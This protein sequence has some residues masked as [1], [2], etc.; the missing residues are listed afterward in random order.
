MNKN[1]KNLKIAI[2]P[3]II[4]LLTLISL[5]VFLNKKAS[6]NKEVKEI[7]I[8]IKELNKLQKETNP[9]VF[10]KQITLIKRTREDV[11]E[12]LGKYKYTYKKMANHELPFE[13]LAFKLKLK[14]LDQN[15]SRYK[16]P[17]DEGIGFKEYLGA[18]LPDESKMQELSRELSFLVQVIDLLIENNVEAISDIQR[19]LI[20]HIKN[21]ENQKIFTAYHFKISCKIQYSNFLFF[22]DSLATINGI[23]KVKN[24]NLKSNYE[25]GD[26]SKDAQLITADIDIVLMEAFSK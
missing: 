21:S 9:K 25:P 7:N 18:T 24:I 5:I 19:V 11:N 13:K 26:T 23:V 10:F 15:Y 8:K 1:I 4:S 17:I 12:L 2:L 14:E 20:E 3:G 16:I 22:L 6:F